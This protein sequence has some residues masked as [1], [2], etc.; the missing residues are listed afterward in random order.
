[1]YHFLGQPRK[2]LTEALLL[3]LCPHHP[4]LLFGTVYCGF[5]LTLE[6]A[7]KLTNNMK[8][9]EVKMANSQK[10]VAVGPVSKIRGSFEVI[11]TT[12]WAI[13]AETT[14]RHL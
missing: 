12:V 8:S 3:A 13:G 7:R 6:A 1:M 11:R 4:G 5:L 2:F 10:T 9:R 14:A